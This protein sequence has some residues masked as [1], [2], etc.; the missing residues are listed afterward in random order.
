MFISTYA[1]EVIYRE[2]RGAGLCIIVCFQ[3]SHSTRIY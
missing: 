3:I 1:H 2:C